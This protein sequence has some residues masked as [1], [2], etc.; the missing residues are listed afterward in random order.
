MRYR[1]WARR[2]LAGEIPRDVLAQDFLEG[3]ERDDAGLPYPCIEAARYLDSAA[4]PGF[5]LHLGGKGVNGQK[6]EARGK[7]LAFLFR[8]HDVLAGTLGRN[9]VNGN[10]PA[11]FRAHDVHRSLAAPETAAPAREYPLSAMRSAIL[12][13]PG[14]SV[15]AA[16]HS[17]VVLLP[18]RH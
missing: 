2:I 12:P 13:R 4:P 5:E 14:H 11:E 17:P 3:L 1:S 9:P 10:Q 8:R 16:A 18:H 6:T 7:G 15:P